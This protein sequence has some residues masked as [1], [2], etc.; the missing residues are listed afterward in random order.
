MSIRVKIPTQLRGLTGGSA[1]IQISDASNL[2]Q[3]I[4]KLG[5]DHP[6][7]VERVI[8]E[9]GDIRRFL[10]VFV[11]D[12]DVRF[13]SGLDTALEGSEVIS[14]LPAVAGGG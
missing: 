8:D 3:L 13:L 2:R 6:D 4:E 9:Q 7:L 14:I 12:E 5:A 11:G 10:N 1:E